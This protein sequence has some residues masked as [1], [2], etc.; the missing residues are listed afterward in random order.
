MAQISLFATLLLALR[1][2]GGNNSAPTSI[3]AKFLVTNIDV[4][5]SPPS[6][7]STNTADDDNDRHERVEFHAFM[8]ASP[9]GAAVVLRDI[10][11][12]GR[13]YR[14]TRQEA[15]GRWVRRRASP[16]F[17]GVPM[18]PAKVES[19]VVIE[20]AVSVRVGSIAGG[21][22]D[23]DDDQPPP[24]LLLCV[25]GFRTQPA[26]W[27]T[28]CAAY[29]GDRL[30]VVPV[31]W[32]A[33]D[34]RPFW[35]AY[36][37]DRHNA[38]FTG[39]AFRPLL[40][41][42]EQIGG[43]KNLMCHS[44]GNFVLKWSAPVIASQQMFDN[45][46]MVAADVDRDI[47]ATSH[48]DESNT[49]NAAAAAAAGQR[50]LNLAIASTCCIPTSMWPYGAA[51]LRPFVHRCW[52]CTDHR[53]RRT[54]RSPASSVTTLPGAMEISWSGIPT[55]FPKRPLSITNR[56]R[57]RLRR[58]EI[59]HKNSPYSSFSMSP[60]SVFDAAAAAAAPGRHAAVARILSSTTTTTR[61]PFRFS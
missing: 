19:A 23:D 15:G 57:R 6:T 54:V 55:S 48:N 4:Q 52:A 21:V 10:I 35:E 36:D 31:V 40:E 58:N 51:R 42:L 47:F 29:D 3:L 46:F 26:D 50:I 20:Q 1:Q 11:D 37:E 59:E 41:C 44:M 5:P 12:T 49:P 7:T 60:R 32:P 22:N 43:P 34:E 28:A 30:T 8:K 18:S 2:N 17:S 24:A 13:T 38:Q 9:T 14:P 45:F 25:H 27:L 39:A 16:I 56:R 53:A 33:S 61:G